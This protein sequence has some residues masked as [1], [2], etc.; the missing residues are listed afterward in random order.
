ME[1][2]CDRGQMSRS[3]HPPDG[4]GQVRDNNEIR[5]A[6][7]GWASGRKKKNFL[8]QEAADRKGKERGAGH[9]MNIRHPFWIRIE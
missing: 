6:A 9:Y 2:A 5:D 3:A 4:I 1:A 7:S 8:I